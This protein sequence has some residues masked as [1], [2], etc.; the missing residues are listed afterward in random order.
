VRTKHVD[1]EYL[2]WTDDTHMTMYVAKAVLAIRFSYSDDTF[3]CSLGRQLLAWYYDPLTPSTAPGNTCLSGM[4]NYARDGEWRTS[5]IRGSDGRGAVMRVAALPIV[6]QGDTLTAAARVS[7][8]I[9][10]AHPNA[11]AATEALCWL[12]R[13]VLEDGEI[14]PGLVRDIAARSRAAGH[15]AVVAEALEA[16]V[17]WARECSDALWLDEQ[18][19]PTF[20]G[21]WRSV[22]AV[23]LAV[24]A[25]LRWGDD[26]AVVI[27][28]AARI[29]GDS[30]SVA[31]IAGMIIGAVH[32]NGLPS[33]G[34]NLHDRGAIERLATQLCA[35]PITQGRRVKTSVHDPIRVA[36]MPAPNER[37]GITLAPGKKGPSATSSV[38]WR[39]DLGIDLG[40]LKQQGVTLV[41]GLME[42]HEYDSR[43]ITDLAQRAA[44]KGI[45]YR[46]FP[47]V[48]QSVPTADQVT[49]ILDMIDWE[50]FDT[51]GEKIVVH[52]MG[53]LGRSGTVAACYLKT[54]KEG[55]SA[56]AAIAL[57]RSVRPGAVENSR[58]E[59]F[60]R[61]YSPG[62]VSYLGVLAAE[63][64]DA[65]GRSRCTDS[66]IWEA[67][68]NRESAVQRVLLHA[69]YLELRVGGNL[70]ETQCWI[71][72]ARS[73]RGSMSGC[74]MP[75]EEW[76]RFRHT[77]SL[78]GPAA[79]EGALCLD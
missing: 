53:G 9:T 4:A 45:E 1:T 3:G 29:N 51:D 63:R 39:R 40:A 52:C 2:L 61:S 47:V 13:E 26:P 24:A 36:W 56:D 8:A 48:D 65:E 55:M 73:S 60:V 14:T 42:A 28:K 70:S 17:A 68:E 30:D 20:D 58:Q 43:E 27:E 33:Y 72:I 54:T 50:G 18:A 15:P 37:L 62:A 57:V 79:S 67:W 69:F 25:C 5:G 71:A 75:Y 31:A 59:A 74:G 64:V 34:R 32:P 10:H 49:T 22:S 44:D 6:Y 21:G 38:Q 35:P 16:A 7:A 46:S 23:G 77:L 41:V 66:I 78:G 76:A 19:I 11:L 12:Q